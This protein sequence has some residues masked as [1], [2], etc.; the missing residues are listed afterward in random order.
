MASVQ[1]RY[2]PIAE[3]LANQAKSAVTQE[4]QSSILSAFLSF[5]ISLSPFP[6]GI[7]S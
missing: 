2:E 4:S 5:K 6:T 7:G 1:A 3:A